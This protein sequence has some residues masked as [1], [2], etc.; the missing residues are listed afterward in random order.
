MYFTEY[1]N[2]LKQNDSINDLI[3]D[4]INNINV[5]EKRVVYLNTLKVFNSIEEACVKYNILR[6]DLTKVFNGEKDGAGI[7]NGEWGLWMLYLEY[8]SIADKEIS[9]FIKTKKRTF[10]KY[11]NDKRYNMFKYWRSI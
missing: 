11:K 1:E 5:K 8:V 10:K 6:W 7:I 4:T 3:N 9:L 2:L